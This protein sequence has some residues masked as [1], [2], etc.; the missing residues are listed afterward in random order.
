[1][2][3]IVAAAKPRQLCANSVVI[4]QAQPADRL[5]LLTQGR[6]RY[7]Y[8]AESGQKLL[9]HWLV[10][11]EIFGGAA[12]MPEPAPYIVGTEMVRHGEVLIW[13]R[14]SIR[15][16]AEKYPR[17][18]DNTLPIFADYLGIYVTTHVALTCRS[19][20]QRLA[21]VLLS[22][23]RSIGHATENGVELDVTN[24]E[25]AN[26][27][28]VTMFTVSR[29]INQ[30]QRRGALEKSRCKLLIRSPERLSMRRSR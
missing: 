12:L 6:A 25:L 3:E 30:W 13:T 1:V 8:I 20:R 19:A 5:F 15:R 16:L 23:A 21:E 29:L 11:G 4:S 18:L 17:L 27:S 7:F 22:L 2:E 28:N 10:P 9:L 24:E 14:N 26:A